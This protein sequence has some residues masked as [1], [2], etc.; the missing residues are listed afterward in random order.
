[1]PT[2]GKSI[3]AHASP[4][5]ARTNNTQTTVIVNGMNATNKPGHHSVIRILQHQFSLRVRQL[6]EGF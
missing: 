1:V 4:R 6:L 2:T 3:I 5:I